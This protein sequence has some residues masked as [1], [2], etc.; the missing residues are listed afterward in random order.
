MFPHLDWSP[1][2]VNS[3]EWTWFGKRS[4][5]LCK[6]WQ[7]TYQVKQ[8]AMRSKG[9]NGAKCRDLQNNNL[10]QSAEE[11][12]LV[13]VHLPITV[14]VC[15]CTLFGVKSCVSSS[16]SPV[17]K[18]LWNQLSVCYKHPSTCSKPAGTGVHGTHHLRCRDP[19]L[20]VRFLLN[21]PR[22]TQY[23]LWMVVDH[24]C[25]LQFNF[26][27]DEAYLGGGGWGGGYIVC[28]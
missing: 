4:T 25:W 11:L 20:S 6:V 23:C 13:Q 26:L 17:R 16:S 7:L 14:E 9:L 22:S 12:R 27:L 18:G 24:Q 28:G 3:T 10:I 15:V 8:P 19:Y 21:C 2:A 5:C 1:P